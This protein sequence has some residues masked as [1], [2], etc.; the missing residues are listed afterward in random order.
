[1][2]TISLTARVGEDRRLTLDLPA[3]VPL[4]THKVTVT[5]EPEP[6]E[7]SAPAAADESGLRY[8]GNVLVYEGTVVGSVRD[9]FEQ[10][11]EERHRHILAGFVERP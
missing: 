5:F 10:G 7:E 4:G 6:A 9:V 1:M 3:D 8:E 11:R 2:T